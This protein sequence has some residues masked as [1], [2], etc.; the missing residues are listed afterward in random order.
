MKDM[1]FGFLAGI[2]SPSMDTVAKVL[3]K[4][5]DATDTDIDNK[6][7]VALAKKILE[8]VDKEEE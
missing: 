7:L 6:A 1:L 2:L 4:L 5:V 3:L 8:R